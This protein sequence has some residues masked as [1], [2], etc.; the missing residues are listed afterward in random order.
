MVSHSR[1]MARGSGLLFIY[2]CVCVLNIIHNIDK[3]P[4]YWHYVKPHKFQ[5]DL[6]HYIVLI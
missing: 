2:L 1:V 5:C 3:T 6:I 4:N